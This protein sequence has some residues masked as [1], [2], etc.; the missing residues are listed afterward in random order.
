MRPRFPFAVPWTASETRT[1]LLL[2]LLLL[3]SLLTI[4]VTVFVLVL[5]STNPANKNNLI[6][7]T[8]VVLVADSVLTRSPSLTQ[9]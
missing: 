3:L 4:T 7:T 8:T 2:L 6:G 1:W 9:G 5:A